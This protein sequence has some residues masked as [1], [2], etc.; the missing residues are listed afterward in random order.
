MLALAL[1]LGQAA[2]PQLDLPIA[3]TPGRD[4]WVQK[5]VDVDPGPA[6]RDFRCGTLTTDG[7]DGIDFRLP[8][9]AAMTRGVAV[10]AA[11]DG[12]VLRVRDG[13]PDR[14]VRGGPGTGGRDAGN[15]VVI[16][17]GDGW[18][19]Q[20]SH[21]QQG[22]VTVRPGAS[23][24]RGAVLG[25][26]GL[27][28]NTEYP[29]LHF[30][31]R[32]SGSARDPFSGRAPDGRCDIGPVPLWSAPARAAL[33]TP[34]AAVV[35]ATLTRQPYGPTDLGAGDP[36][37]PGRT[38]PLVL[39]LE[40]IAV[41]PGD[42]QRFQIAGPDGRALLD[43]TIPTTT[44]GLSWVGYAGLRPPGG[45]WPAGRYTGEVRLLRAGKEIGR[46]TVA[47]EVR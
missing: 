13:E 20:Y 42:S 31:V 23:V 45:T 32:Q 40:A 15:G 19:T 10:R 12:R 35:R 3:C 26:V 17:H 37:P 9:H 2:A 33:A 43:R 41:Q 16:D 22:S 28:G 1:L 24:R 8:S 25:R 46:A 36:P 47:A 7:H 11:A 27:S 39:A 38:A 29:H 14:T 34:G 18:E 30:S 21:L 44:G 4:C 6:R 5:L